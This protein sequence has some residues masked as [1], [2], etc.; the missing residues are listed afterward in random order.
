MDKR[1]Y[2]AAIDN[3]EMAIEQEQNNFYVYNNLSLCYI[4]LGNF[5]EARK[6]INQAIDL[7]PTVPYVY[8]NAGIIYENLQQY[9]EA[10]QNYERALKIDPNY[11]KAEINL[12]RVQDKM[13][14]EE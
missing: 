10:A 6:Y 9:E 12:E 8:N 13:P 14:E 3:F 2:N 4:Q 1:E 7:D 5:S 11:K